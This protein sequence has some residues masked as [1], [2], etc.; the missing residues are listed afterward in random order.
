MFTIN[1]SICFVVHNKS[2]MPIFTFSTKNHIP[3]RC[4]R[5]SRMKKC[6]AVCPDKWISALSTHLMGFCHLKLQ[7]RPTPRDKQRER[8]SE[9]WVWAHQISQCKQWIDSNQIRLKDLV[10][11]GR[12]VVRNM[13]LMSIAK[14]WFV[15]FVLVICN[16]IHTEARNHTHNIHLFQFYENIYGKWME[17]SH[18][19]FDQLKLKKLYILRE[20]I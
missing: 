4:V 15:W 14:W 19:I 11:S 9:R 18:V 12:S 2:T 16:K 6:Y 7:T 5:N 10:G 3:K 20:P 8:E 1:S 13:R 17:A